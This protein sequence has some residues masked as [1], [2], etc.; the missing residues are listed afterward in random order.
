VNEETLANW[1]TVVPENKTKENGSEQRNSYKFFFANINGKNFSLSFIFFP[2]KPV[3]PFEDNRWRTVSVMA[4][5]GRISYPP[6]GYLC[7]RLFTDIFTKII[8]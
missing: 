2:A 3:K 5:S 7:F 4:C 1:G 6:A 8:K